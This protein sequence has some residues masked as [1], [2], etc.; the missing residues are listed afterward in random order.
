M[1]QAPADIQQLLGIP[2]AVWGT[3]LSALLTLA[4]FSFLYAD[5]PVYKAAEHLFVGVS[6]AYGVVIMYW[7]YVMPQL[8]DP[9]FRPATVDL[10]G[11]KYILL[12]PVALGL[13]LLTRF[14]PKIDYLS[15]W[16]I[17]VSMSAYAGLGIPLSLQGNMLVQMRETM[18]PLV[19][20][21]QQV[22]GIAGAGAAEGAAAGAPFASGVTTLEA[23]SHII[24]LVGV[25]CA[26]S[27][28][29]F[30]LEHKGVLGWT[31][32][33][34]IWL[35][36]VAFGAGFGNTVMARIS[37]LIGRVQFFLYD[38][39]PTLHNPFVPPG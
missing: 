15:R 20:I 13:L 29:Y 2:V 3:W 28:F 5:N 24:V 37:L 22:A 16:P 32:R 4:I 14:I 11:P 9:L 35:L 7:D 39:L 10:P 30:S 17:A 36:M 34:G 27:Y 12:V 8:Y 18:R 26:L 33:V 25:I 19:P 21:A 31:S 38:F 6:A 1:E 23:V